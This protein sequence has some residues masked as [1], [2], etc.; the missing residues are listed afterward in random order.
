MFKG[1]FTARLAILAIPLTLSVAGGGVSWAQSASAQAD[2]EP[3][4]HAA[5]S[6]AP[7][8]LCRATRPPVD[9]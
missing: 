8:S 2:D 3:C 9:P 5:L 6:L 4:K 7:I 1:R